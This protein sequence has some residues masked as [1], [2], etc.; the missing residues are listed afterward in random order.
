MGILKW[1]RQAGWV[2]LSSGLVACSQLVEEFV[3][4]PASDAPTVLAFLCPQDSIHTV[5]VRY[6]APAVGQSNKAGFYEDLKRSTVQLTG[7]NGAGRFDYDSLYRVFRLR[8][9][10][11]PLRAG[12]TYSLSVQIPNRT[13]VTASC[14]IPATMINRNSVTWINTAL[15]GDGQPLFTFRWSD[16]PNEVSYYAIFRDIT[17]YDS[18]D[19]Q[20]TTESE[21]AQTT[22]TD[23]G[24][25]NG[26]IVAQPVSLPKKID[27]GNGSYSQ[28]VVYICHTDKNYYDYH[29]TLAQ[30]KR[31]ETPFSEPSRLPSNVTNG[32][33]IVA[34]YTRIRFAFN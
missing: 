21:D 22:L 6:T 24:Y 28:T 3:V 33:G 34:G 17:R 11:F 1:A 18:H 2:L 26:T 23:Q 32:Y 5:E 12:Q 14:T 29:R 9:I 7:P 27:Y 31:D 15:D 16:L 25:E 30:L 4:I 10:R 20:L 8:S 13:P 19:Q